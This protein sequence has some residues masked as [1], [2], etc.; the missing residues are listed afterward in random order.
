MR[1]KRFVAEHRGGPLRKE[2]HHQLMHWA[3]S[4]AEHVLQLYGDTVDLRLTHALKVAEKWRQE[5]ASVGEARRSVF[6]VLELARDLSN[7]VAIAVA[8]SVG[9]AVSTAH[10]ADHSLGAA[11]YALKA[12]KIAG[13]SVEAEQEW[14]IKHLPADVRDL[15]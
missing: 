1:D 2:Q 9:H 11:L 10:M 6:A 15:V 7:P 4:C 5:K 8:R 3:C 12:I 13:E 14:Q